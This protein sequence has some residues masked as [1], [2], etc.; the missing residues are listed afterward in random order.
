MRHRSFALTPLLSLLVSG[1]LTACP[2]SPPAAEPAPSEA[3][4]KAAR[5]PAPATQGPAK[6]APTEPPAA[7]DPY[8]DA[9]AGIHY[10]EIMTG[11]AGPEDEVPMIV[12]I[13]GLGDEPKNFQHVL[14]AFPGRARVIL[15]RAIDD[16]EPGWSWFPIRA[17][18]A[19]V[20]GLSRGIEEAAD[21]IAPAVAELANSR[22][23]VGKPIVTGFSQGGMLTFALAVR[24]PQQFS[25]AVAVGG[26]LPPPM[27]PESAPADFPELVALHGDAD[28]AVKIQPT[29]DAVAHLSKLGVPV[30]LHEYPGV[31][32]AIPPAMRAELHQ[33]LT[34]RLT[35]A[36]GVGTP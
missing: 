5:S 20:E 2:A 14:D 18:S 19:D 24:H 7:P 32:H 21:A 11:G 30:E 36:A 10:L 22:P 34:A 1:A 29:R 4:A 26:W 15:P 8:P 9:A 27:W 6:L 31:G 17:R 25:G 33:L 28:K 23:T 12:A 16:H 35:K 13:H 3:P